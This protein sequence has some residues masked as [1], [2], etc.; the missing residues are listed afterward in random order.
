MNTLDNLHKLYVFKRRYCYLES[1]EEFKWYYCVWKKFYLSLD[2]KFKHNIEFK[3][4]DRNLVKNMYSL[5]LIKHPL[6]RYVQ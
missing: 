4:F 1:V 2:D 3:R 5:H 6:F